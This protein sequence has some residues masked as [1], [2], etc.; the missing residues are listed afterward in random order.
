MQRVRLAFF[1]TISIIAV[2]TNVSE[3][4]NFYAAPALGQNFYAAPAL[5]QYFYADSATATL[6]Q[7]CTLLESK[8][9]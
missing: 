2:T 1:T 6:A 9:N 8:P 3:P 5:D 7:A 4:L